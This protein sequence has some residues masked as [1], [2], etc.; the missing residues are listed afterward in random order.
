MCKKGEKHSKHICRIK[1]VEQ[2]QLDK[3][4]EEIN[5]PCIGCKHDC[6]NLVSDV[7]DCPNREMKYELNHLI[8]L[9]NEENVNLKRFVK[10]Y[11][12]KLNILLDILKG[13]RIMSYKYETCIAH[14]TRL[15]D[16]YEKYKSRFECNEIEME[17]NEEKFKLEYDTFES[18]VI[19]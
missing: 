14:R 15:S 2:E 16:E 7:D 17:S 13:K 1:N 19:K 10:D 8:D 5:Y 12:L 18:E 6:K 4:Y 3:L 11:N 9:L